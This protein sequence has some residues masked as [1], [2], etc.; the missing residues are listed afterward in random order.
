MCVEE[1]EVNSYGELSNK[2]CVALRY[3]H[4]SVSDY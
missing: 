3:T 4:I 2:V 1:Q